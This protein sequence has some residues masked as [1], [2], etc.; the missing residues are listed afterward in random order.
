MSFSAQLP[1]F[2]FAD[3]QLFQNFVIE[4]PANFSA[5]MN[6]YCCGATIRMNPSCMTAFLPCK[7][8]AKLVGCAHQFLRFSGHARRSV[9]RRRE[10]VSS[11]QQIPRKSYRTR[12]EAHAGLLLACAQSRDNLQSQEHKRCNCRCHR[13]G[14]RLDN[15]TT[16]SRQ[17]T[18]I[19]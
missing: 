12:C 7:L 15:Q 9:A 13:V 18:N 14:K 11:F 8:E 1:K 4:P 16:S 6:R 10:V 5:W 2:F 17:Q 19:C 3:S